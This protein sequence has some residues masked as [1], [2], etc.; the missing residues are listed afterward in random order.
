[1]PHGPDPVETGDCDGKVT[2]TDP[3]AAETSFEYD[4]RLNEIEV[5]DPLN[6]ITQTVYDDLDLPVEVTDALSRKTKFENNGNRDMKK[7][8]TTPT[9]LRGNESAPSTVT[10]E[11]WG[12][13]IGSMTPASFAG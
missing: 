13:A 8:E 3:M 12:M 11:P 10:A 7:P 6:R 1:M 4:T 5:T 9:M 2:I